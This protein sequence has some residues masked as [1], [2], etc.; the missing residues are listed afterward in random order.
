MLRCVDFGEHSYSFKSSSGGEVEIYDHRKLV[1]KVDNAREA[2]EWVDDEYDE[3]MSN[4][5]KVGAEA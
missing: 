1:A 4:Q 3:W 5:E 2:E